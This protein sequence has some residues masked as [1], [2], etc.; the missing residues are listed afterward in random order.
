LNPAAVHRVLVRYRLNR[1]AWMD[2]ATDNHHRG[3]AALDG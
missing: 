1:L 2:R 3:H